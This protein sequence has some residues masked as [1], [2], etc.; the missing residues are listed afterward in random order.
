MQQVWSIIAVK[1]I[2]KLRR[3]IYQKAFRNS[4]FFNIVFLFKNYNASQFIKWPHSTTCLQNVDPSIP[5]LRIAHTCSVVR[6]RKLRHVSTNVDRVAIP[7]SYLINQCRRLF[8]IDRF[9]RL[10]YYGGQCIKWFLSHSDGYL[11][12]KINK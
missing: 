2:Y 12:Q 1:H 10:A 9:F 7:A 6:V 8:I 5:K 4:M 3:L 11:S